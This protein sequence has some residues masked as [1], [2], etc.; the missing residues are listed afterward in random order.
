MKQLLTLALFALLTLGAFSCKPQLQEE[1]NF[2]VSSVVVPDKITVETGHELTFKVYGQAPLETD[3]VVLAMTDG[4][5]IQL[6]I[7][8]A[9]EKSFGFI[10]PE[11]VFTD[12]YTLYIERDEERI[13]LGS[14]EMNVLIGTNQTP[15]STS[16]V[17]GLVHCNGEVIK[18]A[19]VSDGYNVVKTNEK[20]FYEF[21]SEKRHGYVFI[22]LPSNYA[23]KKYKSVP[24]CCTNIHQ[25]LVKPA[26]VPERIDFN[27]VK[28]EGQE[29]YTMVVMG[30]MHLAV[31]NNDIQQFAEFKADLNQYMAENPAKYYGQTLGDLAWDTHWKTYNL[32]DFM[33]EIS[34]LNLPIFHTMGNHDN[35]LTAKGDFD[36]AVSFKKIIGPTYYSYN[37]GKVHYVVLDNLKGKYD[38]TGNN[39]LYSKEILDEQFD[40]LKE[41]LKHISATTPVVVSMHAQFYGPN[42]E[43][44]LGNSSNSKLKNAL[45]S[46]RTVHIMSG[47]THKMYNV[48][49]GNLYEHNSGSV[50]ATWWWTGSQSP[51]I[52]VSQD[53]TPGGYLLF[54][55]DGTDFKWVFKPTGKPKEHQFRVYDRNEI[56]L[57]GDA[58][59]PDANA[60]YKQKYNDLKAVKAYASKS[61]S[62][63]V[64]IN[65]WN[66]DSKWKVEVKEGEGSFMTA[67]RISEGYD[68]LHT[69]SY[70]AKRLNLNADP[71]FKTEETGHMFKFT[72]SKPNTTVVVKVTDRFGNIYEKSIY[73]PIAF[74]LDNYLQ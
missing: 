16:T 62:N 38:G 19:V 72:A 69:I 57:G 61:S 50:C 39:D 40:W 65:V 6:P 48:V 2:K 51:G 49:D 64:Y 15:K 32:N 34:D 22:S 74:T 41:D 20:G 31:R 60:E 53:G 30:D 43:L 4:T 27:L 9:T 68:P 71:T 12:D 54:E 58:Y 44:G 35:D 13:K 66:W 55:V 59:V 21:K 8:T 7:A 10:I 14:F 52:H 1:S 24:L 42:K 33:K 18:D 17:Y 47:H 67:T 26:D 29:K 5:E 63:E 25:D 45:G 70:P 56:V 37:I 36:T 28:D 11:Q 3:K 46:S 23:V 73:R